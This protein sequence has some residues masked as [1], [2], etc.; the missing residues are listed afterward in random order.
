MA[1]RYNFVKIATFYPLFYIP[2][3]L[4]FIVL[5]SLTI[6]SPTLGF[7]LFIPI[8]ILH[9]FAMAD[10]IFL[11]I[12]YLGDI[13]KN[14]KVPDNQRFIWGLAIFF[15]NIIAFPIYWNKYIKV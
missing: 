14:P 13:T 9:L 10:I 12:Y 4:L 8:L 2:F 15:G 6:K 3:L 5:F 11:I 1:K 7:A